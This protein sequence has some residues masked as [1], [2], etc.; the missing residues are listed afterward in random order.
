MVLYRYVRQKTNQKNL[1]IKIIKII[2]LYKKNLK[3]S[4]NFGRSSLGH[5]KNML[6]RLQLSA[7]AAAL[8]L[9]AV[10]CAARPEKKRPPSIVFIMADDLGYGEVGAFPAGSAHGRIDT[11][12]LDAMASQGMRF[13][14]AYAGYTVCAPSRTTL[15]TGRHSGKFR[16]HNLPGTSLAPGQAVT[17]AEILKDAG[18]ATALVGKSAPLTNPLE[19]GFDY[20]LG[21]VSQTKCHNMYPSAIDVGNGTDN[22]NLPLNHKERSRELCMAHPERYNY[23]T[24]MFQA[25]ALAWLEKAAQD[26][27]TPFFLYLS[28]TVPHAGDWSDNS[29]E[30]G[31]PVPTDGRYAEESSWPDVEKDHAGV[32]TY[33]DTYVGQI[34]QKIDSLGIENNTVLFFASD[35]GAHLEGGHSYTFFNS[36]GGLRGHKR[37]MYEGGVRSPTIVQWKGTI[38]AGSVSDYPWA[39]WDIMPTMAEIAGSQHSVPENIDGQSILPTLHGKSQAP[40]EYLYF[41]GQNAWGK[42]GWTAADLTGRGPQQSSILSRNATNVPL[43]AYSVRSGRWKAVATGC[44]GKP[45]QDDIMQLYDLSTDPFETTD[46]SSTSRGKAQLKAMKAMIEADT[47]IS[48]DCYQC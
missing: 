2:K 34:M 27:D 47:S 16:A 8:L 30:Q 39:F 44:E 38:E 12:H 28:F 19:S 37:S 10:Q 33:L 21:Q 40:P 14:N 18:Y 36:T 24:D 32:I 6:M 31:A 25:H 20:F 15:F 9:A 7:F 43:T 46:I 35:N 4:Y 42:K 45:S 26:A 48:C 11:P 1:K 3:K 5:K 17:T 13:T 23:T 22:L 41:T 29:I